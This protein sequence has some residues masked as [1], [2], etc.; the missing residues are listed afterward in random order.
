MFCTGPT[1]AVKKHSEQEP[2]VQAEPT[3]AKEGSL[4]FVLFESPFISVSTVSMDPH[5]SLY[6][7]VNP[8]KTLNLTN[9]ARTS[10]SECNVSTIYK[11]EEKGSLPCG[12]SMQAFF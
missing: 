9:N 8:D 1:R 7:I 6:I 5:P 3:K 2:L 11:M 4:S 10:L 12:A